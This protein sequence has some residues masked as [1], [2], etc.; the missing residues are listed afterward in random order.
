[1]GERFRI[2][3]RANEGDCYH[4]LSGRHRWGGFVW[5]F[6]AQVAG[7]DY[8]LVVAAVAMAV[9]LLLAIPL[10]INFA[11][12]LSLD[13]LALSSVFAERVQRKRLT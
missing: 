11:A 2:G 9:G 8:T 4:V 13:L 3:P 10:S 7:L 12:E 6:A 1:V 5:G